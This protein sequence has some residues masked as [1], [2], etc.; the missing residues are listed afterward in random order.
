VKSS[1]NVNQSIK[2]LSADT[3]SYFWQRFNYYT[4]LQKFG[5]VN[6]ACFLRCRTLNLKIF[7]EASEDETIHT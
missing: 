3:K 2:D 4:N 7:H 1:G 5:H 6:I